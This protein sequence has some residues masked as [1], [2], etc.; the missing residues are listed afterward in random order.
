MSFT[1]ARSAAICSGRIIQPLC[2]L[3]LFQFISAIVFDF[4]LEWKEKIAS[5]GFRGRPLGQIAQGNLGS[6]NSIGCC[7]PFCRAWLDG[8]L[9]CFDREHKLVRFDVD[10][11]F[12]PR[13][14]SD[15][16]H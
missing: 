1:F 11:A 16:H 4:L 2:P 5:H 12:I 15:V 10:G 3:N 8:G 7:D 9:I 14:N 6:H 13:K